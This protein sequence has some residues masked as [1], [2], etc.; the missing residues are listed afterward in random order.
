[1]LF[2]PGID[3]YI[4]TNE[5]RVVRVRH[6]WIELAKVISQVITI[7]L[8]LM[9]FNWL[10]SH[11]GQSVYVLMTIVWWMEIGAI[12]YL[13]YHCL[14][15]YTTVLIVT[16][17]RFMRLGGVFKI[18]NDMMPISK[19]TDMTQENPLLGRILGYGTLRIESA[20]QMQSLE[21]LRY[22]P[23]VKQVFHAIT[24]LVF[25]ELGQP[26][27]L[28]SGNP[29]RKIRASDQTQELPALDDE[30]SYWPNQN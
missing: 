10:L 7:I 3:E 6:H 29:G 21:Y 8:L 17:K 24:T 4:M 5:R 26:R 22:V 18:K 15:W 9:G 30:Q 20:G 19:V 11:I 25:D 23:K 1:M 14:E 27:K 13:V 28:P 12:L 16:D 2:R